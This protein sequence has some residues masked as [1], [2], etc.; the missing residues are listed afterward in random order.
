MYPTAEA[1]LRNQKSE[2]LSCELP[3]SGEGAVISPWYIIESRRNILA[4]KGKA[5]YCGSG[6]VMLIGGHGTEKMAQRFDRIS[7]W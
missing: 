3:S 1:C 6:A 7:P 2:S 4:D 5:E